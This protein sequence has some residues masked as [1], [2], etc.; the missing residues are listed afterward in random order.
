MD[1]LDKIIAYETEDQTDQWVIDF[2]QE[3][4][5]SGLCGQ[6][7]GHYGRTAVSLIDKGLVAYP[8]TERDADGNPCHTRLGKGVQCPLC[9]EAGPNYI[10]LE[11]FL[12]EE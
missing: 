1:I 10:T 12:E 8:G 5:N 7:Q 6:L 2:F 9:G 4:V 11:Q 3:L